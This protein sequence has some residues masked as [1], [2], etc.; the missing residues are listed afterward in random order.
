MRKNIVLR[1][2][3]LAG[4]QLI[5]HG[6]ADLAGARILMIR[7][8]GRSP[9]IGHY[10]LIG[11]LSSDWSERVGMIGCTAVSG[12]IH[13]VYA[14]TFLRVIVRPASLSVTL[15]HVME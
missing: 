6:I 15:A 1:R 9:Q 10:Q 12:T 4:H 11:R 2:G 13:H 5:E 3:V 7:T 8:H 14:M